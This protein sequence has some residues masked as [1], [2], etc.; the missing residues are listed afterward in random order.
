MQ[1]NETPRLADLLPTPATEPR[2]SSLDAGDEPYG[3]DVCHDAGFIRGE[4]VL[5][6]AVANGH[7]ESRAVLCPNCRPVPIAMGI[8]PRFEDATFDTFDIKLNPSMKPARLQV[9]NVAAGHSW[10]A[11]LMGAPGLGKSLLAAG[12]LAA[13]TYPKPGYFWE[14]GALL[15]NL[16]QLAFGDGGPHLAEED[17]LRPWQSIKAL[18]VLDDVGAEKMTEWAAQTLYAILNARYQGKLPTIVTT[19]NPDAIDERI[20]SRLYEGAVVCKGGD[21]RRL[22]GI[23]RR[24]TK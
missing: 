24:E 14:W 12:A 17:V 15:R 22:E 20:I 8:P 10:C 1:D 21:I 7:F 16:R 3:C 18:L 4:L 5:T 19:N 13:S 2:I 6:G 9:T 11:L 23:A